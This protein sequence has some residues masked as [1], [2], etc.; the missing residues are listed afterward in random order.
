MPKP[1]KKAAT[2]K[3]ATKRPASAE[4]PEPDQTPPHGDPFE[5]QFRARMAELGRKG[6]KISGAKRMQVPEKKRREIALKA[7]RARWTKKKGP[8]RP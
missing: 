2:R 4:P 8:A 1:V 5:E 7:A 3:P 6:G